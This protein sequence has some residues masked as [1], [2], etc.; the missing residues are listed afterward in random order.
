MEHEVGVNI[1]LVKTVILGHNVCEMFGL[2]ELVFSIIRAINF[3]FGDFCCCGL[4]KHIKMAIMPD[5]INYTCHLRL[6]ACRKGWLD[7]RSFLST[8]VRS[9]FICICFSSSRFIHHTRFY[10]GLRQRLGGR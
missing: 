7:L 6:P 5:A 1:Q 9:S 10:R 8:G 2:K 4:L 3:N